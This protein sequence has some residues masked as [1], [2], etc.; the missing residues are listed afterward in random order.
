MC[1]F[2]LFTLVSAVVKTFTFVIDIG[3]YLQLA[4]LSAL[5]NF[6]DLP[7]NLAIFGIY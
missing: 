6:W 3:L 5:G 1:S 4:E 7:K 2:P